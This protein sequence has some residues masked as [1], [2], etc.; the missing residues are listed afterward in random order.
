MIESFDD[1]EGVRM[2]ICK[3]KQHGFHLGVQLFGLGMDSVF[4]LSDV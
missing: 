1:S 4:F 3:F 2:F